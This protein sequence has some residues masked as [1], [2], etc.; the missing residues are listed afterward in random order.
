MKILIADE[1]ELICTF[2]VNMLEN[3]NKENDIAFTTSHES[4]LQKINELN[5]EIVIIDIAGIKLNG[6]KLIQSLNKNNL[7]KTIIFTSQFD[8][9]EYQEE[10][11]ELNGHFLCKK[12]LEDITK[13]LETIV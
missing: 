11:E 12:N 6:S 5:P 13:L 2:I 7:P 8:D 1:S 4:T 3:N 10:A 9:V